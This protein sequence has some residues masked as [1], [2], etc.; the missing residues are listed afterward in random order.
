MKSKTQVRRIIT[1]DIKKYKVEEPI[2]L[3]LSS[4]KDSNL[5]L[6][7]LLEQGIKPIV[8][9]FCLEGQE[10]FDIIQAEKT[11]KEKGLEFRPIHIKKDLEKFKEK[12]LYIIKNFQVCR[13]APIECITIFWLFLEEVQEKNIYTGYSGDAYSQINKK[14]AIH[15][16]NDIP[17][18]NELREKSLIGD[19]I[20]LYILNK[21]T[22]KIIHN[23][24]DSKGLMELYR[25]MNWDQINKPKQKND[26]YLICKEN[27]IHTKNKSAFQ[28]GDTG[29]RDYF[30]LLLEDEEL[31]RKKRTRMLDLYRDLFIQ[32]HR[33]KKYS[34][35]NDI[36]EFL[37]D[38]I[39]IYKGQ[40]P[41]LEEPIKEGELNL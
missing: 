10:S 20:Q 22:D 8:Y 26:Y 21:V 31:N 19:R 28:C 14:V 2:A 40:F 35:H 18:L 32:A 6:S 38:Y 39:P 9:S 1:K 25:N 12:V 11:A 7:L 5:M 30:E 33:D 4:G 37:K 24:E 29:F 3:S 17:K 34:I 27:N 16:K 13:K 36:P 15:Y 41:D 23:Y